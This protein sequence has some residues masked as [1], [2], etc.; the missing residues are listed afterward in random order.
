MYLRLMA[1]CRPTPCHPTYQV[2]NTPLLS[3]PH[4]Q[5]LHAM[6]RQARMRRSQAPRWWLVLSPHTSAVEFVWT[7]SAVN[8]VFTWCWT[9]KSTAFDSLQCPQ[10]IIYIHRIA[11]P[12]MRARG[13]TSCTIL[14]FRLSPQVLA[15]VRPTRRPVRSLRESEFTRGC[16]SLCVHEHMGGAC[17]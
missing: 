16:P 13:W 11:P 9:F 6:V 1:A 3:L 8:V 17:A 15:R 14:C 7:R 2:V 12:A 10:I 4:R 5:C